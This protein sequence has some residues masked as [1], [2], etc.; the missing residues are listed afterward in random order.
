MLCTDGL[1]NCI[2][3]ELI[4]LAVSDNDFETLAERLVELAN[5]NGGYDNITAVAI[6]A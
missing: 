2:D 5:Q 6:K 1:T 4:K 3:D